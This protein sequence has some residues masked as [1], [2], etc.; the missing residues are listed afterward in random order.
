MLDGEGQRRQATAS[1]QVPLARCCSSQPKPVSAGGFQT[2]SARR[3]D[4]PHGPAARVRSAKGSGGM[5][6]ASDQVRLAR[7]CPP[8]PRGATRADMQCSRPV[9]GD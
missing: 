2:E 3:D 4:S 1:E 8:R 9:R 7:R 5:A 6:T